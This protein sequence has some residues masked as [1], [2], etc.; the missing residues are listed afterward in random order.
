MAKALRRSS[1]RIK[2]NQDSDY[3]WD[4]EVIDA[5]SDR[6]SVGASFENESIVDEL[7]KTATVDYVSEKL[8][9][10]C[11]ELDIIPQVLE[12]KE[13]T[14][15]TV[16]RVVTHSEVVISQSPLRFTQGASLRASDSAD[17]VVNN[18]SAS[19]GRRI[20]STREDY[21]DIPGN[22][23]SVE[24]SSLSSMSGDESTRPRDPISQAYVAHMSNPGLTGTNSS[25][26]LD[27]NLAAAVM[28]AL[29]KLDKVADDIND[30]KDRV[31][32]I[33]TNSV[34]GSASESD[35]RGKGPGRAKNK[36]KF[37]RVEFDKE[38]Q[39]RLLLEQIRRRN[40]ETVTE[41]DS[42]EDQPHDTKSLKN[43]MSRK[44]REESR[45]RTAARIDQAGGSFPVEE[46]SSSSSGSGNESEVRISKK[47]RKKVKSGA[48][49]RQR[50]VVK[51]ELWPHTIANEEDGDQTTSENI[52]LSKFLTC[53]AYIM[54]TCEN[55]KEAAG[56]SVLHYAMSSM[57]EY[58]PWP[59]I[60]TWHNLVMVKIEQGR[61]GWDA[62]FV[63][64]SKEYMDKKVRQTLRQ[65]VQ[66]SGNS[67]NRG[68]FRSAGRGGYSAGYRANDGQNRFAYYNL[69]RQ[70]NNGNCTFGI[71]CKKWHACS[72]CWE[73]GKRGEKHQASSTDCPNPRSGRNSQRSGQRSGQ[74][75]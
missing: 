5:L 60:R 68:G 66:A 49:V 18:N 40:E 37:E 20:S 63:A 4:E 14:V 2:L 12:Y 73:A 59:E 48:K 31:H 44:Q 69:C 65:K 33:E 8:V 16:E 24:S 25:V 30:L 23:L 54:N 67:G 64:Q 7:R 19:G 62:D 47:S 56:R 52:I 11:C 57:L 10:N 43:S 35:G 70:W 17:S 39:K 15:R 58:L 22:F 13:N 71:E 21:I 29:D 72:A 55:K 32:N 50:S 26:N 27:V 28:A 3:E 51:T 9:S 75:R 6:L 45:L 34:R 46:D 36:S 41:T 53:Y 42:Q 61:F 1:R 74:S 38:R